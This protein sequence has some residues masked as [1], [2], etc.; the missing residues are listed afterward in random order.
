MIIVDGRAEIDLAGRQIVVEQ[1][2]ARAALAIDDIER[3]NLVERIAGLRVEAAGVDGVEPVA[4]AGAIVGTGLV[5][6]PVM[7]F[8]GVARHEMRDLAGLARDHIGLGRPVPREGCGTSH[9]VPV[10]PERR[11]PH[12]RDQRSGGDDDPALVLAHGE[13]RARE[14]GEVGPRAPLE[15]RLD[16]AGASDQVRSSFQPC[17]RSI[18]TRTMVGSSTVSG[19]GRVDIA[20]ETRPASRRARSD[21]R[22]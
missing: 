6:E 10:D 18:V 21:A 9:L 17:L 1:A 11:K 14:A 13:I 15:R 3:D 22:W 8:G 12:H 2:V 19:D 20:R 5:A 16:S 7:A 4:M